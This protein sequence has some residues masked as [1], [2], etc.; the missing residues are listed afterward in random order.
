MYFQ[1]KCKIMLNMIS[2]CQVNLNFYLNSI[3]Y[4]SHGEKFKGDF[5]FKSLFIVKKPTN[6]KPK[7][8]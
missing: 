3:K 4:Y 7:K 2:F 6:K 1:N 5:F 8:K